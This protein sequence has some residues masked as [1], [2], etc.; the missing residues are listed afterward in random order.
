MS[1]QLYKKEYTTETIKQELQETGAFSEIEKREEKTDKDK[2]QKKKELNTAR[3]DYL[4]R[5]IENSKDANMALLEKIEEQ[6]A[7]KLEDSGK[8]SLKKTDENI[9]A[10]IPEKSSFQQKLPKV[11]GDKKFWQ[12]WK[13][14]ESDDVKDLK[15]TYKN[16]DLCT[17]REY[18]AMQEYTENGGYKPVEMDQ[19]EDAAKK[20]KYEELVNEIIK[21]KIDAACFTD[22]YLSDNIA[23]LYNFTKK[24][25]DVDSYRMSNPELYAGLSYDKRLKFKAKCEY[26]AE[27][28][29]VLESHMFR[30]GIKISKEGKI[31]LRTE[32]ANKDKRRQDRDKE[33]SDYAELREKFL[34]NLEYSQVVYQA[35]A[36]TKFGDLGT[37]ENGFTSESQLKVTE[38]LIASNPE[39]Y[40]A[41]GEEIRLAFAEIK[42]ALSVRD[43][44]IEE[45]REMLPKY[46][47]TRGKEAEAKKA[48]LKLR[49][50]RCLLSA[51]HVEHY[52]TFISYIMGDVKTLPKDT[53]DFLKKEKQEDLTELVDLKIMGDCFEEAKGIQ[54]RID[55]GM[56]ETES[57]IAKFYDRKNLLEDLTMG[58]NGI[59]D[60]EEFKK[61]Y[62]EKTSKK[63]DG[64]EEN[65]VHLWAANI[66]WADLEKALSK[67]EQTNE[68]LKE[69]ENEYE[70]N[71]K[72]NPISTMSQKKF[73]SLAERYHKLKKTLD[74][75]KKM[76]KDS[77]RIR[78]EE[79]PKEAKKFGKENGM[80]FKFQPPCF[81]IAAPYG[82]TDEIEWSWFFKAGSLTP[83][84]D[85]KE[86]V[87]EE[88]RQ[89]GLIPIL[90]KITSFDSS[91]IESLAADQ[92][93]DFNDPK[94][95]DNYSLLRLGGPNNMEGFRNVLTVYGIKLSR[96]EDAKL[97]AFG[98]VSRKLV[99]RYDIIMLKTRSPMEALFEN[100]NISYLES[101]L[102]G[103]KGALRMLKDKE[104]GC[105]DHWDWQQKYDRMGKRGYLNYTGAVRDGISSY[106]YVT[107][108]WDKTGGS[109]KQIYEESLK[110]AAPEI[111]GQ[112]KEAL[113]EEQR[114]REKLEKER[115]EK[116][117]QEEERRK[118]ERLEE[119]KLK[120]EK[121]KEERLKKERLEE[122]KRRKAEQE[123]AEQE[124]SEK[125]DKK[126]IIPAD[127]PEVLKVKDEET[128]QY[129]PKDYPEIRRLHYEFVLREKSYDVPRDRFMV[130]ELRS[131]YTEA[132]YWKESD[133]TGKEVLRGN[134]FWKAKTD[135][136]LMEACDWL[137]GYFRS[138][139]KGA[140]K[141]GPLEKQEMPDFHIEV[142]GA[143]KWYEKQAAG[144]NNC[145]CC[146][147]TAMYNRFVEKKVLKQGD[148][149][150]FTP[151]FKKEDEITSLGLTASE[152]ERHKALTKSYM[153]KDSTAV[154]NIFEMGDFFLQ[155]NKDLM[156]NR[157]VFN[158]PA[159]E[160]KNKTEEHK[161]NDEILYHN[162]KAA[163]LKQVNEVL[164][165][166][167]VVSI[168]KTWGE[169][170]H[171]LTIYG[172]DGQNLKVLD[173]SPEVETERIMTV[174]DLLPR[175]LKGGS[176]EITWFSKL[177][178]KKELL[179][180][181]SNLSYNE[182]EGFSVN[183]VQAESAFNLAQTK[184]VCVSR[185]PSEME[186]GMEG[187][188]H[189]IYIPKKA[190]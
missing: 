157:M 27:M 90:K 180:G 53:M 185:Y 175:R 186:K 145:W 48:E 93:T 129:L 45:L 51:G 148:L 4:K 153:G 54:R 184:G 98:E 125:K 58:E 151:E 63:T 17:L 114:S 52:R 57:K 134:Y 166:K 88:I 105:G 59:V 142:K 150:E 69:Y 18:N 101:K 121:L 85:T 25:E 120:E 169:K 31:I 14:D 141:Q 171:Y 123:K 73:Y 39:A 6:E 43:G 167:N 163:F 126:I 164:K 62:R 106:T 72:K 109:C 65:R 107:K 5:M 33:E 8:K 71:K 136:E 35:E 131:K 176:T 1:K 146:A 108:E 118:K 96:E 32:D 22:E 100:E 156:I 103:Q 67:L 117:R 124:R 64:Y 28:K 183:E 94:T 170:G 44:A 81:S 9:K 79:M 127:S 34:M 24:A 168:L 140:V 147:G 133:K 70:E 76:L 130:D 47:N 115:L 7:E 113:E 12:V 189:S 21:K 99:K 61:R 138:R 181:F 119:E 13:R 102:S 187:I 19:L 112:S 16:A 55:D 26:A 135:P 37:G 165:T 139:D 74:N 68:T 128:K 80:T 162:Q 2:E 179:D 154:G 50:D 116:E 92:N 188:S 178:T 159:L 161:L 3:R 97:K 29:K 89:R 149:R 132:R 173:S 23:E 20:K 75:N 38:E 144:S 78:D 30:H 111:F 152:Y 87:K 174:E 190:G 110:K 41:Y 11:R 158:P 143:G 182:K 36:L 82:D 86:E 122:E 160:S 84:P 15:N 10:A 155:K 66:G 60:K 40:K 137:M 177:K 49:T 42:K 77:D 56:E 46:Y 83:G 104:D 172:I 91:T 95:W